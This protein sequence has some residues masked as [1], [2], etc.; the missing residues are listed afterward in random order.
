MKKEVFQEFDRDGQ[1]LTVDAVYWNDGEIMRVAEYSG[2]EGIVRL[3]EK[4]WAI[5]GLLLVALLSADVP[6]QVPSPTKAP[7]CIQYCEAQ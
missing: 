4:N 5:A 7:V 2:L 6:L 3:F 1:P